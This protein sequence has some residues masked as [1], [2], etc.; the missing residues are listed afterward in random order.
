ME[1][2][3]IALLCFDASYRCF[4]VRTAQQFSFHVRMASVYLKEPKALRNLKSL[5]SEAS[6]VER[7]VH[8]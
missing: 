4:H 2:F 5:L 1:R 7:L 6:T 8:V 3:H